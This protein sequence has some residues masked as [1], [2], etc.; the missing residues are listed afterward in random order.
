MN[1]LED[2]KKLV[3]DKTQEQLL[4]TPEAEL[5]SYERIMRS[6]IIQYPGLTLEDAI[7]LLDVLP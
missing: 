5:N 4:N 7:E 6:W 1:E 2:W 3:T